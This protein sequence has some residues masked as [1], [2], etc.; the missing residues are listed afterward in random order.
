MKALVTLMLFA[1]LAASAPLPAAINRRGRVRVP[2]AGLNGDFVVDRASHF[3]RK[4]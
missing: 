1:T 2:L 4:K 3:K